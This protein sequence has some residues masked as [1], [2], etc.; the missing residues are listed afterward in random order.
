MKY[1]GNSPNAVPKPQKN[2]S[3]LTFQRIFQK[4]IGPVSNK[5]EVIV[6]LIVEDTGQTISF[7]YGGRG[8]LIEPHSYAANVT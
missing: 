7:G 1:G 3:N 8:N 4:E 5:S 2:A 6:S